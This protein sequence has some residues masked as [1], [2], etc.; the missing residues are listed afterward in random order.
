MMMMMM[1]M[2]KK[3]S[4]KALHQ[5]RDLLEHVCVSLSSP[6]C[7]VIRVPR[8]WIKLQVDKLKT[9]NVRIVDN[10]VHFSSMLDLYQTS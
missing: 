2:T 8:L 6:D 3:D 4:V 1:I 9:P 7:W 10:A 5:N